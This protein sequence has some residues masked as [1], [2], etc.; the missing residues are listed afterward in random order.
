MLLLIM[1]KV[2]F[3]KL[4]INDLN[5]LSTGEQC[6][7]YHVYNNNK[8]R[9]YCQNQHHPS[10]RHIRL[11]MLNGST[12]TTEPP[13]LKCLVSHIHIRDHPAITWWCCGLGGD[14]H[15]PVCYI[16]TLWSYIFNPLLSCCWAFLSK[17]LS[18]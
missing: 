10:L 2:H 17:V 13:C 11:N 1:L 5:M 9:N 6:F 16:W 7:M 18:A 14:T 8:G 12:H 3:N 4:Q 15:M